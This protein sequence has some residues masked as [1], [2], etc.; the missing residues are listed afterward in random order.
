MKLLI[1]LLTTL[2]STDSLPIDCS[3]TCEPIV[4]GSRFPVHIQ[5][6]GSEKT[7]ELIRQQA[8]KRKPQAPEDLRACPAISRAIRK[9]Y[10]HLISSNNLTSYA[11]ANPGLAL[12][13]KCNEKT[14]KEGGPRSSVDGTIS[15]PAAVFLHIKSED[16]LAFLIAHEIGHK[17]SAHSASQVEFLTNFK[18]I[19]DYV[20][21]EIEGDKV[22]VTLMANAGYSSKALRPV[23]KDLYRAVNGKASM[24]FNGDP[25]K[26][27]IH[28]SANE[29][30]E[31]TEK[32]LKDLGYENARALSS[33]SE[34]LLAREEF[35][36]LKK[37]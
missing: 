34:I 24:L 23:L 16:E 2:F 5:C 6:K 20:Q 14:Y 10:D 36:R 1:A 19:H 30:I 35:K 31:R 33:S 13:V 29:R 27:S 22:G 17:I 8:Q 25:G 26:G 15:I 12:V 4:L 9:V 7:W 18:D 3:E 32:T 11:E 28:G 37:N 21:A